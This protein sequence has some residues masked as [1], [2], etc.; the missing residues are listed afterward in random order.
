VIGGGVGEACVASVVPAA[1]RLKARRSISVVMPTLCEARNLPEVIPRIPVEVHEVLIVDGHSADDTVAVAR[2]LSP[3]VRVL[4]QDG[5]GKGDALMCGIRAARGEIVVTLDADGSTDPCEIPRFVEALERGADFAKGSRFL[6]DGGSDD[7]TKLRSAGNWL[8]TRFVNALFGTRYTDLCYGYN[9]F[10]T[11]RVAA[12]E[13]DADGFE[14]ETLFAL[15]AAK[16]GLKIIEVPSREASRIHG[17]SNLHTFRDGWCI[18]N[19]IFRERW[20]L[21]RGRAR[22]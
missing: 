20:P 17:T 5:R 21:R 11:E 16:A 8:L 14:I 18:L 9:A 6:A 4:Y 15:R 10:W 7:I 12:M 22:M 1:S 19:L 3:K 13:I 2:T